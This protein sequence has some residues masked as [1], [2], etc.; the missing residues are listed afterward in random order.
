[1]IFYFLGG[2]QPCELPK[3]LPGLQD[4]L[5]SPT[6]EFIYISVSQPFK[7]H[8]APGNKNFGKPLIS[9]VKLLFLA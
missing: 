2:V 6:G 5:Q 4:S 3:L 9:R 7:G 8:G 1:M